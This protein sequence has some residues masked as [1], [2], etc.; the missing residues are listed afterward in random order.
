M[1]AKRTKRGRLAAGPEM[2]SSSNGNVAVGP[3]DF[4][5]LKVCGLYTSVELVLVDEGGFRGEK[6]RPRSDFLGGEITMAKQ[7]RTYFSETLLELF[8]VEPNCDARLIQYVSDCIRDWLLTRCNDRKARCSFN[9]NA[10]AHRPIRGISDS[11]PFKAIQAYLVSRS[12]GQTRNAAIESAM[13]SSALGSE[14]IEQLIRGLHRRQGRRFAPIQTLAIRLLQSRAQQEGDAGFLR[15]ALGHGFD[16]WE[17]EEA[18]RRATLLA[19]KKA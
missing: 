9:L 15:R 17:E 14:R 4:E 1:P 2:Q 8:A 16:R 5:P 6:W 7:S 12:E 13:G 18:R 19:S 10:A 3:T 11:T